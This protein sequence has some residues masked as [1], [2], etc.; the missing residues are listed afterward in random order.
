MKYGPNHA[1]QDL[2]FHRDFRKTYPVIDRGEG[3]YLYDD[4]GNRFVDFGSGIGV[5][6]LGYDIS[7]VIEAMYAQ[8]KKTPFVYSA[9]FASEPVS[10]PSSKV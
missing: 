6:N 9:P 2:I 8:A 1:S 3:I 7:S 4:K 10:R 5:V